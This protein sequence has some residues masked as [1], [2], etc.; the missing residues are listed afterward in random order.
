VRYSLV[1]RGLIALVLVLA[2]AVWFSASAVVPA[3]ASQWHLSA[4][5]AAWLTAP[6]QAGFVLGAIV[7]AVL[8]G[9]RYAFV[10]LAAGPVTALPAMTTL[11]RRMRR[12]PHATAIIATERTSP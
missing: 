7:S 4:G 1:Q 2:M 12:N 10:V 5:G 8:V 11:N 6:V 9:W 3:L